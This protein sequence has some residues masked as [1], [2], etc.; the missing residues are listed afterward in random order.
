VTAVTA[1]PSSVNSSPTGPGEMLK[2]LGNVPKMLVPLRG[3][4]RSWQPAMGMSDKLQNQ[5]QEVDSNRVT[6]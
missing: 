6:F 5:E 3:S 2:F 4:V 1:L